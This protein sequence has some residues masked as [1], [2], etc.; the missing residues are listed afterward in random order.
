MM[1]EGYEDRLELDH[2]GTAYPTLEA[3][4]AA[5][6]VKLEAQRKNY[7]RQYGKVSA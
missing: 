6:A 3:A 2:H 5:A 7:R 4:M 1:T